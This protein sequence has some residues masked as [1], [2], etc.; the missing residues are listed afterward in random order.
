[1]EERPFVF[2][3][4]Q[5]LHVGKERTHCCGGCKALGIIRAGMR[6]PEEAHPNIYFPDEQGLS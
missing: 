3:L 1:M 6:S 2:F 4:F 5:E